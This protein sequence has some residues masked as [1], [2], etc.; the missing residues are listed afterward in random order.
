MAKQKYYNI[1]LPI[2]ILIFLILILA[3]VT[4]YLNYDDGKLIFGKMTND[5]LVDDGGVGGKGSGTSGGTSTPSSSDSSSGSSYF[6]ITIP[7][8]QGSSD[9]SDSNSSSSTS[10]SDVSSGSS[11]STNITTKPNPIKTCNDYCIS[12]GSIS[13]G[14]FANKY[15]TPTATCE[16]YR[17]IYARDGDQYC[18]VATP[19]CCCS[20]L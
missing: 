4:D 9:S 7:F 15:G 19:V 8:L 10:P 6:T 20:T 18:S 16:T 11:P 17:M 5:D 14:C 2:L 13:G 12:L 1:V 3:V